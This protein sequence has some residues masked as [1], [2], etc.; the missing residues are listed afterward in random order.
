MYEPYLDCKS[1][2]QGRKIMDWIQFILFIIALTGMYFSLKSDA[3]RDRE[4]A[5]EDRREMLNIMRSH[6]KEMKDFHGRLCTLEERYLQII[7]GKK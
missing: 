3:N 1:D 7:T 2:Q 5:K 4:S 6:E